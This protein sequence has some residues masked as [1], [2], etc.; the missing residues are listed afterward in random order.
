MIERFPFL[1]LGITSGNSRFKARVAQFDGARN[2][3]DLVD[4]TVALRG[5]C[6]TLFNDKRQLI[7]I[8]IFVP[9][10]DQMR[11]EEAARRDPYEW[12]VFPANSL[13]QFSP[14]KES[15]HRIRVQG[16]VTLNLPGRYLFIQD[17]SGGVKIESPQNSAFQTGDRV[18][19]IGFPA[20]GQYTPILED[21]EFQR[22]G[23]GLLP[24]PIDLTSATETARDCD[25]QM[26][27]IEGKLIDQTVRGGNLVLTMQEGSLIYTAELDRSAADR[28]A[29]LRNGAQLQLTGVWSI[30]TDKYRRPAAFR[31]LLRSAGDIVVLERPSWWTGA[32]IL[33]LL[34]IL[35]GI[36]L[37]GALW[38][39]VLRR[40]VD[41]RT[42]TIRATLESTADG[43][44]VVDA[45]GRISAFNQKFAEMWRIPEGIL[46]S[47]DDRILLD[48]TLT[49]LKDPEAF[50]EKVRALYS[51]SEAKSDDLIEFK[52]GR[53][54]ERHSEP[55]RVN[56]R[57]VGRVWGFRDITE[58]RRADEERERLISELTE[59]LSKVKLLGGLLPICSSCKKI[60]EDSGYWRQI[61]AYIL[62]HSEAV[63]SHSICPQCMEKL[64]PEYSGEESGAG[65]RRG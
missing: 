10:V 35:V 44:L 5:V 46:S 62:E 41:E 29:D 11:I 2:Y 56:N 19:A 64:Y 63:F 40:S 55:Q 17:L 21:G 6:G 1:D 25:A 54:F 32:R 39:I 18:D 12:P 22:I 3:S 14:E 43:I 24:A 20:A 16:V 37:L 42:E 49:Q 45:A 9:G 47:R 65:E 51:D 59:A 15:G 7:G 57:S 58:Q 33:I 8:Q 28:Q 13:M 48:Y 38:V 53:I 4:A 50:I 27:K 61:E 31:V 34:A 26:V 30:E 52:D 36:I 23:P 60:R